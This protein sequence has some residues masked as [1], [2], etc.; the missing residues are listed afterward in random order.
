MFNLSVFLCHLLRIWNFLYSGPFCPCICLSK[1]QY[2]QCYLHSLLEFTNTLDKN[3]SFQSHTSIVLLLHGVN[4]ITVLSYI[5][6][7]YKLTAV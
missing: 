1:V 4:Q 6:S 2:P 3:S 7:E 5:N